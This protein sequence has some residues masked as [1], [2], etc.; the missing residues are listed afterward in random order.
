[1]TMTT[2]TWLEAMPAMP[3]DP[4]GG[5]Y[6]W[7]GHTGAEA[8][9]MYTGHILGGLAECMDLDRTM[10]SIPRARLRRDIETSGGFGYALRWLHGR[11]PEHFHNMSTTWMVRCWFNGKTTD[12]DLLRV[13]RA[14]REAT[15]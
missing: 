6:R 3:L 15:P 13:A 5:W 8:R 9:V 12:A 4:D 7:L 14:L 1:M 10:H 2:E 11:D